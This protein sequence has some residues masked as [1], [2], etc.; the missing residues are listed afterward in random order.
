MTVFFTSDLHLEHKNILHH[1]DRPFQSIDE[2]DEHLIH[3]WN[4][5][6]GEGDRVYVIGDVSCGKLENVI[7]K[8]QRLRGE[9]IL[10]EG[11][12]DEKPLRKPRFRDLFAKV[13]RLLTI[14]IPIGGVE[15]SITLCHYAMLL[16]PHSHYGTWHLH[17]HSH[18]S[19]PDDPHAKRLDVGV[20]VWG[21]RPVRVEEI[22]A[23]MAEKVFRPVDGHRGD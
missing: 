12:H 1:C 22:A 21:F 3:N 5:M 10:I 19:L 16:W 20:D 11:N 13:E 18:G 17:G 2:H 4:S 9:K 15:Q 14:E 8:V 6:V 23:R 7:Q